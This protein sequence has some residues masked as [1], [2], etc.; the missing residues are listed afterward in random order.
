M[1]GRP[2]RNGRPS[3]APKP[4]WAFQASDLPADPAF[5][6][7]KLANGMRYIIRQN[8][9]PEGTA[10]VRMEIEAGSLD[11]SDDERGYAHFVEHMAF[12]GS[13]NV[14]EGEMVH[15][16]ERN[17]LAFGA[18]TNA[19]TGFEQTQYKLDLPRNDPK[20]LD[21]ALMLMRETASEL[22]FD[23]AAV[24]RERGVVLS[25]LR[26]SLT[27][28]RRNL[29]DQLAFL[30]PDARYPKRLPIGVVETLNKANGANLKAFWAREYTPADT[31]LVVIGDFDPAAVEQKIVARF[32]GWPART[33]TPRPDPGKVDPAQKNATDVF[34]DPALSERVTVSRHGPYLDEPDTMA[35]RR[36]ALLREIGY[37]IVNRRLQRAAR[38]VDPPFRGAGVGTSDVF[39]IGR[40]TNLIVD[41]VDG[42]WQRGLIAAEQEYRRAL[43]FGFTAAEVAEQVANVRARSLNAARAAN[44]RTNAALVAAAFALVE[45]EQVPTTPQSSHE[46]FEAFAPSITPAAVMAAMRVEAVPLKDPLIRLQGRTQP[47]GGAAAI[48]QA[49][50]QAARIKSTRSAAGAEDGWGY[51]DFG[52]PGT[53]VSD[54]RDSLLGIRTV[55]FANGVMLNLKQT[56]LEQDRVRM[57]L[58]IDGGD[59]LNTRADPL[60]TEMTPFL[61]VG[62][63][64]KHSQDELQ[65]IL[66]GRTVGGGLASGGDT[67]S[68]RAVTTPAD[69]ELQLQLL[70]AYVAD[71]G[72]RPEG[73][74]QYRLNIANFFAQAFATPGAALANGQ[75]AVISDNDPRYSLGKPEAYQTLTFAKLKA[76][77][78]ERLAHG[79]IE[80]G[81]VGDIDE[82]KGIALVAKTFGALPPREPAFQPYPDARKRVF[83]SKRGQTIIRHTGDPSQAVVRLVWPTRDD[84]DPIESMQLEALER[85]VRLELTD[86]I[87]EKLGKSYSPSA[88]SGLSRTYP[89]YGE[90]TV[91][92]SV[93]VT[94]VAATRAAIAQIVRDLRDKPVSADELARA[95]AP[96]AEENANLLKTNGGWM[97]LVD[98]AQS[99]ADLIERYARFQE[100]LKAVTAKDVQE[101]ARRYLAPGRAVELIVLPKGA[102]P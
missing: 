94:D 58:A 32:G 4:D 92:A 102:K 16:L 7:G 45:D 83:T 61:S 50:N 5:R 33:P 30:Y 22:K 84:A 27:Y 76:D 17:G 57:S 82:D 67:F 80:I 52:T 44:T 54:T 31:T 37:G 34:I 65:S 78:G 26:D 97:N 12:N 36:A 47:A 41:V 42:K 99:Q 20:L 63:L 75:G 95:L 9:R 35:N 71:A 23:D 55:R 96:L 85:V 6:F 18:D 88:S 100:R 91:T 56:A 1:R 43:K 86:G 39:K 13:T 74:E 49:W 81:L 10:L 14:P 15:L 68:S 11:E 60:A 72:Y 19:S 53:V 8:R 69:L 87:R 40:T 64:G 89:G 38:Q 21:T 25:E 66:A 24:A 2:A 79:A 3:P 98:R 48:R 51:T 59:M 93:D 46:R 70:A 28:S 77:I 29:E 62:G 90:F 73:E 101:L